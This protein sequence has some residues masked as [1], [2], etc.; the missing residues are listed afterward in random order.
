MG[1]LAVPPPSRPVV[2]LKAQVKVADVRAALQVNTTSNR[3]QPGAMGGDRLL[4]Q[5]STA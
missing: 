2:L 5:P 3:Y 1:P 4:V